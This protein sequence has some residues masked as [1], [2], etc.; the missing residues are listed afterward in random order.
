MPRCL[1]AGRS[2]SSE[3]SGQYSAGYG[4]DELARWKTSSSNS[5]RNT[6]KAIPDYRKSHDFMARE[7]DFRKKQ[8]LTTTARPFHFS[9]DNLIPTDKVNNKPLC[10]NKTLW[11][12]TFPSIY[13]SR[14]YLELP[15]KLHHSPAIRRLAT[16][17]HHLRPDCVHPTNGQDQA[18]S[19]TRFSRFLHLC[20]PLVERIRLQFSDEL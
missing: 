12:L 5:S 19:S 15:K 16:N 17:F 10:P 18:S 8:N 2:R 14:T 20:S 13:S 1:S 11:L 9:T 7:L 4:S 3:N 6:K